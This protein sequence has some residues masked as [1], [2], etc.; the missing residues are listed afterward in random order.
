MSGHRQ[1][2]SSISSNSRQ[3]TKAPLIKFDVFTPQRAN[4]MLVS[5]VSGYCSSRFLISAASTI[6]LSVWGGLRVPPFYS[7]CSLYS[8]NPLLLAW[9]DWKQH[10]VNL[11]Q[12]NMSN[13][14]LNTMCSTRRVF[15]KFD[16]VYWYTNEFEDGVMTI[17]SIWS[18]GEV[19]S[20]RHLL[21]QHVANEGYVVR[22]HWVSP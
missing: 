14:A 21:L 13:W 2:C 20:M 9:Q 16:A 18:I 22:W 1:V 10:Q 11:E 12:T 5:F 15:S 3:I 7:W 6:N 4:T 8:L 17:N 19:D